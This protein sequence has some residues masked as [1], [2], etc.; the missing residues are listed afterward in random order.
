MGLQSPFVSPSGSTGSSHAMTEHSRVDSLGQSHPAL[1]SS[2]NNP[3]TV[4]SHGSSH[5]EDFFRGAWQSEDLSTI[6]SSFPVSFHRV[7]ISITV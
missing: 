4:A 2:K 3:Y 7:W 6:P 5:G 1:D